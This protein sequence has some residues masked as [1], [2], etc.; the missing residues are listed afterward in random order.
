MRLF[1]IAVLLGT[2][3]CSAD[4]VAQDN[5]RVWTLDDGRSAELSV[6]KCD[7]E[8]VCL[9]R[10]NGITAWIPV[11][12]LCATDQQW[13]HAH[14]L[15]R[16]HQLPSMFVSLQDGESP[17]GDPETPSTPPANPSGPKIYLLPTYSCS[18]SDLGEPQSI[19]RRKNNRSMVT[20][21]FLMN[22][23]ESG[24]V[25]YG[26]DQWPDET[27]AS[28]AELG[29]KESELRNAIES[30]PAGPNDTIVFY[31]SGHGGGTSHHVLAMS[32][33]QA[34]VRSDL[35]KL[36]T[37]KR[38]RLAAVLTDTCAKTVVA[39]LAMAAPK[40]ERPEVIAPLFDELFLKPRGLV[41]LNSASPGEW[42]LGVNPFGCYFT[43]VLAG[44]AAPE[45]IPGEYLGY[46]LSNAESRKS[47]RTVVAEL[48]VNLTAFFKKG[49][50]NGYQGQMDQH[51]W[52]M[53][54]PGHVGPPT[55]IRH[56]CILK[57]LIHRAKCRRATAQKRTCCRRTL[58]FRRRC[59]R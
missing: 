41:N 12:R 15:V 20:D 28:E 24:L 31:W 51:I 23:P 32:D 2:A 58:R 4:Q 7:N 35:V 9:Q 19:Q 49:N 56:T 45:D 40:A 42:A 6:V 52:V 13:L 37:A 3:V 10:R 21:A 34:V 25:V 46:L 54:L 44:T 59:C 39:E 43:L 11:E 26:D 47:W 48:Q 27:N 17:P 22:V 53:S 18:G 36:V 29:Y 57:R 5:Y 55:C 14:E 1:A 38:A 33:N 8:S 30:C 50:P 16:T